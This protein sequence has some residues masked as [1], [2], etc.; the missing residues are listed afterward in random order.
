M[1]SIAR[2]SPIATF[3]VA[4]GGAR[5]DAAAVVGADLAA[6]GRLRFTAGDRA[7]ALAALDA[8]GATIVPAGLADR[9]GLGVGQILTVPGA[10]GA[11]LNLR[12]VGIVERSIPGSGG[13]AMLVGWNDAISLGVAGAD[14]FAIRF[15]PDAPASARTTCGRWPAPTRST[16][17][18]SIGS[19]APSTTRWGGSSGS[20]M[21]WR[22]SRS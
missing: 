10:T 6:D 15:A 9:L 8:G 14:A 22:R 3:D 19:R 21:R 17:S 11:A 20:S 12:I 2:I 1:P 13:E 7:T 5:T 4:L 16:T 18:V